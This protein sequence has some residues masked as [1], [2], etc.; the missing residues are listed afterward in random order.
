MFGEGKLCGI[1]SGGS[2]GTHTLVAS[3]WPLCMMALGDVRVNGLS[4]MDAVFDSGFIHASDWAAA[5][6]RIGLVP[7]PSGRTYAVLRGEPF[8]PREE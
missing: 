1:V 7:T 2:F 8:P 3:L 4:G 5:K 6:G